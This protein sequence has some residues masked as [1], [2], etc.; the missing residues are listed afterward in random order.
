MAKDFYHIIVRDALE[1]DG[2]TITDDPLTLLTREEGGIQTD[3]GAEKIIVAERGAT[4]IAVE[5]KSF[6]NP[7]LIHDFIRA[8]GQFQA[9]SIVMRKKNIDRRMYIAMPW[10]IYDRLSEFQFIQDIIQEA[11]IKLILFNPNTTSIESWIE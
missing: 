8:I 5:V 2:W 10:F 6:L 4:K 1:K 7:S 9:Y 3:L 11:Q